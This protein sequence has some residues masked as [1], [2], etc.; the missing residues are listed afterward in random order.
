MIGKDGKENRKKEKEAEWAHP[1]CL[2]GISASDPKSRLC[3]T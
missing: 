3:W 2:A 1:A